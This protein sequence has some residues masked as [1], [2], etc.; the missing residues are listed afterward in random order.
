M[1]ILIFHKS[2]NRIWET[3]TKRIEGFLETGVFNKHIKFN[4]GMM[5]YWVYKFELNILGFF[6]LHLQKSVY[7]CIEGMSPSYIFKFGVLG[8]HLSVFIE[9]INLPQLMKQHIEKIKNLK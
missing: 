1:N 6:V 9:D 5:D 8:T 3:K 4:C 7:K 2:F